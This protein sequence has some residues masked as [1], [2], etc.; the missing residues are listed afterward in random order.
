MLD[1]FV[2]AFG[3]GLGTFLGILGLFLAVD[4]LC[5]AI[6]HETSFAHEL[7]RNCGPLFTKQFWV[8]E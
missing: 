1:L 6:Q 8:G 5:L 7:K 2:F 3:V 4:S